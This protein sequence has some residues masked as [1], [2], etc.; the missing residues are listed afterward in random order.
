MKKE[1]AKKR[2]ERREEKMREDQRQIMAGT[3]GISNDKVRSTTTRE[4]S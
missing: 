1:E 2:E 4:L 3:E